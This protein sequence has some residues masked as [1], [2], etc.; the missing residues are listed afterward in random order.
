MVTKTE[1]LQIRLTPDQKA[2]LRRKAER[3]GQDVSSYVLSRVLPAASE[4]FFE[5]VRMVSEEASRRYALAEI[6]DLLAE[7]SP[8][9]L[10]ESTSGAEMSGLSPVL[11]NYVAAMVEQAAHQKGVAPPA[12]V[13]EIAPLEEP[14][15]AVPY[16][17]LRLYLLRASPVAFRRRNIFADATVGDRV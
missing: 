1:Q 10:E 3:A 7:L 4:R 13:A 9:L 14:H 12:W 6:N 16:P 11:R 5:L 8:A 2:T 15:F 17:S